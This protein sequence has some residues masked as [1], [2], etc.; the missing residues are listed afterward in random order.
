[1]NL[2]NAVLHIFTHVIIASFPILA[3]TMTLHHEPTI[4]HPKVASATYISN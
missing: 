2:A 1:M 3:L 4:R